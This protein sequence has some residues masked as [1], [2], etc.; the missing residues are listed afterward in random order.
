M[1]PAL[2]NAMSSR[3]N[4]V[5][6]AVD[7]RGDLVLVGDVAGDA[8][9]LV[10]GGGQLVGGGAERVLVDVG[11]HDGGAGRGERASGV[12]PHAGAG[13]GDQRDLAAGSRRS[14]SCG[15][16]A[17]VLL[18]GDVLAPGDGAAGLVVLLHGEVGHEAVGA[19]PCQWFSPGSKNTRSPGRI[20]SIGP[21]SRWQRPMPSVT[22]MVWRCGWVC[23]AVRGAGS[24][25]HERGGERGGRLGGGDGVDVERRR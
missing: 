15:L 21:P 6:G 14:G 24:E 13:A 8:E 11:E 12:E 1:M 22:K 9:R 19:A 18:V 16:P 4:V 5:D 23:Q 2:L 3:P 10:A 25:V 17:G 7:E 20:S